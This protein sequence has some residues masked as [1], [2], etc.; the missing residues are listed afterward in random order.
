MRF[1]RR[2]HPCLS[3]EE[4]GS[5]RKEAPNDG[6]RSVGIRWDALSARGATPL[7]LSEALDRLSVA[8]SVRFRDKVV[9]V[10]WDLLRIEIRAA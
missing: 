10:E 6:P 2:L 5:K 1:P 4:R 8:Q 9:G 7:S 3:G